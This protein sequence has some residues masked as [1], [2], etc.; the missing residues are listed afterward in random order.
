MM[1]KQAK[2]VMAVAILATALASSPVQCKESFDKDPGWDG[3][4]N[5]IAREQEPRTA[6]QDFGYS[7]GTRHAGGQPGEIGGTVQ[8]AAEPAYYAKPIKIKTLNDCLSASGRLFVSR[9]EGNMLFGFFNN[10]TLNEWRTPNAM[11]VR[12]QPRGEIFYAHVEFTSRKWRAVGAVIGNYDA[13]TD[14]NHPQE[15]PCDAAY[16]WSLEYDPAGN[17]GHGLITFTLGGEK[18]VINLAPELRGDGTT[19]NHFGLLN[20]IKSYDDA[21]AL[22]LDDIAINGKA[23]DFSRDPKWKGLRNRKTYE[24]RGVRPWF[25]FGF[26]NTHYAGG[27]ARGE[28]GGVV[29]RGDCRYPER[30]ACY[31]DRI[32]TLTLD[33]PLRGSGRVALRRGVTDSTTAIGFY[34][35]I[36]SMAVTDS[37]QF[38][39]PRDF[40]GVFVE[41]PSSQGFYFYPA[42]RNQLDGASSVYGKD[43]LRILPD[44]ATHDWTLVYDPAAAEGNG[45]ITVTLDGHATGL[46]LAPGVKEA[47][48]V[49]DRFGVITTWIDGNGQEV[50]FD[51]L[52]YTS[53]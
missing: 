20:V 18:A 50:Y 51:D 24:T 27:A 49:F 53:R 41:G 11:V 23:Q 43:P 38:T 31:G 10:K 7:P 5:R 1:T 12:I 52:E 35:S 40:L 15:L 17:S 37:Q 16:E 21:G 29:Y 9:G 28:L 3:H 47:G 2:Y 36:Q 32:E 19:F 8:P 46:D 44:G 39:I 6:R 33:R 26:S 30:M 22:W 34:N 4:N 25:D 42:C 48:A 45:R 13:V 14:R